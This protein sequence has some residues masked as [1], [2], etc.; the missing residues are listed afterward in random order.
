MVAP[1]PRGSALMGDLRAMG[2]ARASLCAFVVLA[3]MLGACGT[4]KNDATSDAS[5]SSVAAANNRVGKAAPLPEPVQELEIDGTEYSFEISPDPSGGLKPG[6]TLLKFHNIGSEP[7]QAMFARIK[8]GVDMS[9]LAAAGAGDSSGAGAIEFVDMIGGVS[10]IA[11]RHDTTAMVKL[12]E[13][14]VM[15]MCYVPDADGVAHALSGMTTALTVSA[16]ADGAASAETEPSG[17]RVVG[18]IEM[19]KDGYQ[20]PDDLSA[21]WY[22]VK[23]TDAV[24]HEMSLL[25]LGGSIADDRTKALVEDLA[26]NKTPQVE[27]EAVGGMGAISPG[28]D[29][30]LYLDSP[31]VT[32]WRW[33]S[34]PTRECPVPTCST[35]TTPGSLSSCIDRGP[36]LIRRRTRGEHRRRMGGQMFRVTGRHR[37]E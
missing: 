31:A 1:Q 33:T 7:H 35:A 17:K 28:F 2:R 19:S 5:S 32:T 24:L 25:R 27:L 10:Y 9:A 36:C 23:N 13:G 21:G 34:C 6:W 26:A 8:D 14:L 4:S 15:A 3:A 22:H 16:P 30:Y 12:T 11:S 20:I 37:H 18:T 29:G